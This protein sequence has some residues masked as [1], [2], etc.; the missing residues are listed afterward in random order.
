VIAKKLLQVLKP[1][2]GGGGGG[3]TPASISSVYGWYKADNSSASTDG[4]SVATWYD[5]SGKGNHLTQ[6]DS[7]KQPI[8]RAYGASGLPEME[9]NNSTTSMLNSTFDASNGCMYVVMRP[10]G[11]VTLYG[12]AFRFG[13]NG[14]SVEI[15][16]FLN[17]ITS[18]QF[19]YQNIGDF[20]L[21]PIGSGNIIYKIARTGTTVKVK[22]SVSNETAISANYPWSGF[23]LFRNYSSALGCRIS[24]VIVCTAELSAADESSLDAYLL[25]KYGNQDPYFDKVSVLLH[26]DGTNGSTTFIDSGP[27]ALAVTA[28]GNAQ[29]NTSGPKWGTGAADFDGNGDSLTIAANSVFAFGT[30]DFTIEGWFY[31]R[32]TGSSQ[33]GMID[34]R[35]TASGTNGIMLRE[36]GTAGFLVWLNNG[37]LLSTATGR[38][39]N[40]WQ[41]V[42]LVRSGT[43]ITLFVDGV[44]KASATSSANMTDNRFRLSGFVDAQDAT[45]T[46]N[47]YM[48]DIRVTKGVARTIT[49]PTAAFP[50][51]Y[52]PFTT[53]PVSGAALWL[54]A[55]QTS[56]LYTDAGATN[57]IKDGDAVYQWNDLSGNNRHATQTTLANRPTWLP[58]AK[59]RSGLGALAFNGSQFLS[60]SSPNADYGTGDFTVE[61][62]FKATSTPTDYAQI[63]GNYQASSYMG[64][65]LIPSS[66]TKIY[67]TTVA[68]GYTGTTNISTNTWYHAAFVRSSGTIK[69]YLNGVLDGTY[70]VGTSFNTPSWQVGGSNNGQK[71]FTGQIQN[72]LAYKGQALYTSN[73]TPWMS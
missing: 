11:T 29:I 18:I 1:A 47:G 39:A 32:T 58:P 4:V 10:Y 57:V 44:S 43:T 31:S 61:F 49:V 22:T 21:I 41:H 33:R 35:T 38:T 62:W 46:Y 25:A 14:N 26:M 3:W 7:T 52:N 54:S 56:S 55:P 8:Y 13:L 17:P 34:F 53:L 63:C 36:D 66:G 60:V 12:G 59:G 70:T 15:S 50:D 28:A 73:F 67:A 2:T 16:N 40:T 20:G 45:F 69:M 5:S 24:E 9:G 68:T 27:N 42:A 65:G 37:T 72:L 71:M 64:F 51:L 6:S 23:E 19:R 30:G 48:D